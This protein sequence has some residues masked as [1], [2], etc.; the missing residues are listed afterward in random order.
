MS[1][2][3]FLF[4]SGNKISITG[5]VFVE[6]KIEIYTLCVKIARAMSRPD[7]NPSSIVSGHG[8]GCFM[9]GRDY[10]RRSTRAKNP[11]RRN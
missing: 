4:L 7:R 11:K 3:L 8:R 5:N 10:F 9:S 6:I 1:L 2:S